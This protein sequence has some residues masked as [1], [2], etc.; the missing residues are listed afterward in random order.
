MAKAQT[1]KK[2]K[3]KRTVKRTVTRGNVTYVDWKN[4]VT[5]K[6]ERHAIQKYGGAPKAFKDVD[7]LWTMMLAY[8]NPDKDKD[9]DEL[10]MD[11]LAAFVGVSKD[12]LNVYRSG[13]YDEGDVTYSLAIEYIRTVIA[14]K[15]LSRAL[16]NEYNANIAKFDLINNHGFNEKIITEHTGEGGGPVSIADVSDTE[17]ARRLLYLIHKSTT[18]NE[19]EKNDD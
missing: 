4:P 1:K 9:N 16:R 7:E 5:G 17:F 2:S 19:G 12:T 6:R 18:V 10:T 13:Q 11:G 8:V 15:K 3:K 14:S